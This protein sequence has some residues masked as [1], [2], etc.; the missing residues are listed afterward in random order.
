ETLVQV[1]DQLPPTLVVVYDAAQR[2]D[3]EGALEI[4]V[5]RRRGVDAAA[6][7]DRLLVLHLRLVAVQIFDS[8][9]FSPVVLDIQAFQVGGP[10]FMYPHGGAVGRAYAVAKPLVAAFVD[11]DEVEARADADARPVAVQE[12]VL[13]EIAVGYRALM[14]HARIGD[15][16]QLV[17]VF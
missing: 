10:A 12:A 9:R 13:E 1:L 8:V 4:L 15:L 14:L 11:D 7:D 16:N 5:R 3:E 17:A 6:G 2:V